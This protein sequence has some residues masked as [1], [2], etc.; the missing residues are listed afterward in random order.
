MKQ[1]RWCFA[2]AQKEF[3]ERTLSVFSPVGLAALTF[4]AELAYAASSESGL[5]IEGELFIASVCVH[6]NSQVNCLWWVRPLPEVFVCMRIMLSCAC[7]F[8]GLYLYK[9]GE[10]VK[11]VEV[12]D[13]VLFPERTTQND[14]IEALLEWIIST[15]RPND[16]AEWRRLFFHSYATK[17][18]LISSKQAV[19]STIS[20][21]G[22]E[23]KNP[24]LEVRLM[25]GMHALL[26]IYLYA[27]KRKVKVLYFAHAGGACVGKQCKARG[28]YPA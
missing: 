13:L 12:Q 6:A 20:V 27:E 10:P 23:R 28:R 14:T 22:K 15:V 3:G 17:I 2:I 11:M 8:P 16:P 26:C 21:D 1:V 4:N 25:Y 9:Q 5:V 7:L 19:P 18:K 24:F